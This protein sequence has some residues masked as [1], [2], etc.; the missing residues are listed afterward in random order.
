MKFVYLLQFKVCVLEKNNHSKR[1]RKVTLCLSS[2]IFLSD[3]SY[4]YK[5]AAIHTAK[6]AGEIRLHR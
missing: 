6:H 2:S 5:T 4:V 3:I 1:V